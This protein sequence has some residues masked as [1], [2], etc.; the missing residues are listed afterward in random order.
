MNM[1]NGQGSGRSFYWIP[2]YKELI[3]WTKI[4]TKLMEA[5]RE[6]LPNEAEAII[7]PCT[8]S[9]RSI[10]ANDPYSVSQTLDVPDYRLIKALETAEHNFVA[11]DPA[12]SDNPIVYA[13]Q[14]F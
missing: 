1:P 10:L 14:G 6:H 7:A 13:S 2:N 4:N 3:L 5:I 11:T 12:F 9:E 8:E